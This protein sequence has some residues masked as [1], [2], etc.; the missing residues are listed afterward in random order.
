MLTLTDQASHVIRAL[1]EKTDAPEQ[2]GLR[3]AA[4]SNGS[5]ALTVTSAVTP[6]AGDE[7]VEDNGA[8][9]FLEPAAATL[10]GDQMLDARVDDDGRVEFML[11]SS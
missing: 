1:A 5:E 8:R 9:V 3:I 7:I 2:A 4:P 11:A 10:L 6:E